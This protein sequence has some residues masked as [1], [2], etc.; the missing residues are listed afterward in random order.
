MEEAD[1]IVVGAGVVGLA[2]A[3]ELARAGR[4]VLIVEAEGAIGTGVSSRNSEVIHAGIYYPTGLVKTRLCTEGRARLYAFCADYGILHRRCGKILVATTDHEIAKLEALKA[5]GN[6][7]GV[8]DLRWLS[9]AEARAL[10]PELICVRALLSPSTGI[11]DSHAF[12]LALQGDAESHGAVVAFETP[13]VG[14]RV[15]AG[16][17]VIETGGAEPMR[18]A[19]RTVVNTAGLGAQRLALAIEGLPAATVPP[20]HL[21]KG[22]YFA[23][24]TRAPFSHLIYPMPVAGGLGV[25]LTLDLAGRARF[26]PDVEWIDA[27]D[28]GVDPARCESFYSAIRAY[29]PNLADGALVPDYCGIRPK[30]ERPGGSTTDFM[31]SGPQTHGVA[32]L[33]NLFGIESPGLTASLAIG[34]LVTSLA[35]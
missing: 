22:N 23:L 34:H 17:L 1:C 26:G 10:E 25:H 8:D 27:V 29:W 3:R 13:V 5:Q 11:I 32:G 19:A 33:F 12:M 4:E 28:Y 6:A 16:R 30:I 24:A 20:L 31:I 15:E 18:L 35:T 2:I 21:A 9:A 7:N 14:G